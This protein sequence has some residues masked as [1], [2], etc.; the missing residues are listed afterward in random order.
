MIRL[1]FWGADQTVTG[2]MHLLEVNGQKILMDC[3][4]FQGHR[5]D[6]YERNLNFPFDPTDIDVVVLS[7]AHIDHSGNL[8]NLVKQG[9]QGSIWATSATRDLCGPMLLDSG[10]IQE[11]DVAYLNK[12]RARKGESPV[13]PLYTRQDAVSTL[14]HFVSI[15]YERPIFI[16]PGVQLTFYD[17]GHILGSAIVELSIM[18]QADGNRP[19]KIVFSGDLGRRNM[20]ILRP[21]TYRTVADYVLTESTY[22]NRLHESLDSAEKMLEETIN[23]TYQRRGK[24]IIPSFAVG[25]TQELVYA[26]H[27]LILA[28]RI[29]EIPFFVDSPLAVN[30]TEVFRLHPEDYNSELNS[31]AASLSNH[32]PFGFQRLRYIRNVE[33]SKSLNH[34]KEPMVIISASGMCEAG[35]ILHHL[36]NNVEDPDNCILFVGYQAENTLGRRLVDGEKKVRIFGEPYKVRARVRK[37]DGYSAHADRNGLIAWAGHFDRKQV[38]KFFVVHGELESAN[39]LASGIRD[40]GFAEAIVPAR[41]D[42]FVL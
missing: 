5:A 7:H 27:R 28:Q 20:T 38:R 25:R 42:Q 17:A 1:Q 39:A 13:P 32:D 36:K 37:I 33:E 26:L 3:G 30:V 22:G 31:F 21:P 40:L 12:K 8:P 10:H 4:L 16:A 14:P 34:R 35:R 23:E 19:L 11:S 15:S 29:P 6:T 9:F 2:S 24:V 18:D 41:G